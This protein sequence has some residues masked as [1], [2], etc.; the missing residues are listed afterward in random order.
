MIILTATGME[1]ARLIW[2]VR[3]GPLESCGLVLPASSGVAALITAREVIDG[4]NGLDSL[5]HDQVPHIGIPATYTM[6]WNVA[7]R[8]TGREVIRAFPATRN[9]VP[10]D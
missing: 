4:T 3:R 6:R 7:G 9:I 8:V 1:A 5:V 10:S 2:V